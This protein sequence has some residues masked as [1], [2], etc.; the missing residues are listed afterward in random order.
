ML[1]DFSELP[2]GE[3]YKLM[4]STIVPRPIAWVVTQSPAGV[5]NAAPFSFFNALSGNPPILGVSIGDSPRGPGDKDTLAN[6]KA[7][8]QFVVCLVSEATAHAMNV[9]ATDM[10]PEVDELAEAN[11]TAAPSA[12]VAPPRIAESPVAIECELFQMVE[13]GTNTL[14]L[15]K[16][17]AM[18]VRDD[19]VLNPEKHYIDTP[20]LGLIG[21]MH[22]RGW[23]AKTTDRVEIPRISLEDWAATKGGG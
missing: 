20:K 4:V 23:Y 2:P 11:L 15:G 8:G 14:V 12:K 7:T 21:R 3:G 16:I 10:P 13:L 22:G 9:T 18:Q 6:I 19:C 5:V 17:V 1:F